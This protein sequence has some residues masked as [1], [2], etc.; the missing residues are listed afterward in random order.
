[1]QT[2]ALEIPSNP[3]ETMSR[4]VA[5]VEDDAEVRQSLAKVLERSPGI[6]CVAGFSNAEDALKEIPK[7]KPQILLMDINLPGMS[8]VDCVR[9]LGPL[10]P[11]TLILMLTVHDDTDTIFD[12]L[13]AGASGY[14]LK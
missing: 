7:I 3:I 2:T 1:M 4:T 10:V 9:A 8:G 14:L 11:D 13:S 12:A 5:I 6:R